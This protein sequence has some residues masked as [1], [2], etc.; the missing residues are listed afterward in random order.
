M[1]LLTAASTRER[2]RVC[3]RALHA[4]PYIQTAIPSLY[5]GGG[6]I[7]MELSAHLRDKSRT[8]YGKMQLVMA[9]Y[10]KV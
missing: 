5:A 3:P 7:E 4:P 2:E 6:A 10:A 1:C 9:S 8:I